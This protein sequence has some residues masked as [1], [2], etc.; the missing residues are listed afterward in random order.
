MERVVADQWRGKKW[1]CYGTSMTDNTIRIGRHAGKTPD[2]RKS[3]PERTGFYSQYLA[4][5]AGLEEHNFGKGG[6]GI[7]P[8]LHPEDSVKSRVMTLTDGKTEADL[9]TVE[10]IPNDV[11]AELGEITDWSDDTFC[12]N[13]NQILEYLLENTQAF[14]AI[15]IAT[16]GRYKSDD[17]GDRFH[18]SGETAQRRLKW[19]EAVEKICRMHG[20]PCWNGA[21]EANLGYFRVGMDQRYVYDQVH[22]TEEG[23]KVLAQYFWGKLQQVYPIK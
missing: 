13:L 10:V 23:G 7:V 4:A 3:S 19:E 22:L 14:V 17:P 18:P 9:I 15:L 12:G 21:A 8:A 16:R 5:Y 1:Y 6:K 20:V 11:K 2:G